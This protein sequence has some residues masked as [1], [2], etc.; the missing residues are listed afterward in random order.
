[1]RAGGQGVADS[2]RS[3]SGAMRLVPTAKVTCSPW[4]ARASCPGEVARVGAHRRPPPSPRPLWQSGQCAAQQIR[5][6]RT[7]VVGAA[8]AQVSGQD[9]LGPGSHVR[10]AHPL[11]QA[12]GGGLPLS[13]STKADIS[14]VSEAYNLA[15]GSPTKLL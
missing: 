7:W 8:A 9:G 14:S 4:A 12:T 11:R 10:A 1:M 15:S 2:A 6:A 3:H 5:R 13:S